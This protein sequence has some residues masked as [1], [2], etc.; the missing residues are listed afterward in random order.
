MSTYRVYFIDDGTHISRPPIVLECD[1]D[2]EAVEKA[3][4]YIDG[5]DI[6][7]WSA[8]RMVTAFAKH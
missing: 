5:R 2:Q 3:R 6:E 8:G 7:L 4:Q 1:T